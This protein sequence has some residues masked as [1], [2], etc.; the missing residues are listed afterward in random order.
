[1]ELQEVGVSE[2]VL[3][4]EE[5]RTMHAVNTRY[6]REINTQRSWTGHLWQGR[7]FS[8]PLDE[9]HVIAA[10]RYVERNPVRAGMVEKAE[11]YRWSSARFHVGVRQDSV[12]LTETEWGSPI[13][14][15]KEA[16]LRPEDADALDRIRKRTRVGFPCGDDAFVGRIS[17]LLGRELILRPGGRPRKVHDGR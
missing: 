16:L 17:K 6:A 10:V 8:T 9:P 1:M 13:D 11:E 7:Y 14:G 2:A 3:I 15:W 5:D 12:I 4:A